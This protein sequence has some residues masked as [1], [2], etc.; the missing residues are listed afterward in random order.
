[1][2]G[3]GHF[4][5]QEGLATVQI[6]LVREHTEVMRAP[7]GLWVPFMLGRPLGVPNDPEFQKRVLR[8]ALALLKAPSGPLLVDYAEEA[9]EVALDEEGWVCPISFQRQEDG[10]L[11]ERLRREI[12]QYRTWYDLHV[13]RRG[14]TAV[15]VSGLDLESLSSFLADHAEGGQAP[16]PSPGIGTARMLRLSVDDLK[17]FFFEAAGAQPG[18]ASP[19]Q[20]NE[21][22]WTATAAG[23]A[24][25]KLWDRA[26][27]SPEQDFKRLSM[28][29]V[30]RE[31]VPKDG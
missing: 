30:P 25:L 14:R 10:S 3:L 4:L 23:E 15:G 12:Q 8:S 19:K 5:E 13:Q 1:V 27:D 11:G 17:T 28:L 29:I 6:S 9:P 21:W 31:W 16:S 22:F 20:L 7:R 2:S 24:I 18:A 26:K